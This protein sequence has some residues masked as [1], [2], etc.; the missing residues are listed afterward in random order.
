M[1]FSGTGFLT[2][3]NAYHHFP[4]NLFPPPTLY[5]HEYYPHD[6]IGKLPKTRSGTIMRRVLEAKEMGI[7]PGDIPGLEI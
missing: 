5:T 2:V 7:D 1:K 3:R 4:G 6:L